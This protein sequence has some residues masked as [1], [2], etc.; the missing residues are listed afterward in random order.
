M[1]KVKLKSTIGD[2]WFSILSNVLV[3]EVAFELD[4]VRNEFMQG[5]KIYPSSDKTWRAFVECPFD[6]LK[7][8]WIGQDPYP[9]GE[10]TGLAFEVAKEFE[11]TK[12]FDKILD[13]FNDCY[14]SHFNVDLLSGNITP[15]ANQ[16][17]LLLNTAL[18]VEAGKPNSHKHY[19]EKFT[20]KLLSELYNYNKDLIFIAIGKDAQTVL[21][22][23]LY[24]EYSQAKVIQLEHPAYAARQ[25]RKWKHEQFFITV[26]E[27]LKKLN[28]KEID[29]DYE[30]I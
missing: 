25:G 29:W 20:Q 18:S 7:V 26:N 8:V 30:R 5:K 17:V 16:G 6:Q 22:N 3:P 21:Q 24:K 15:W 2:E 12:S 14:P 28:L 10:A 4:G 13:A 9:N 27:I 19:W 23:A 1:N 11:G